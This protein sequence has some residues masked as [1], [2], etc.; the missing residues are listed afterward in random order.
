MKESIA[1]ERHQRIRLAIVGHEEVAA[2][3]LEAG[4]DRLSVR[5]TEPAVWLEAHHLSAGIELAFWNGSVRHQ[6]EPVPV[7]DYD[8]DAGRLDLAPPRELRVVQRRSTFREPVELPVKLSPAH[9]EPDTVDLEGITRDLSGSGMCLEATS[10]LPIAVDDELQVEL[11]I[12]GRRVRARGRVCWA[13][14]VERGTRLGLAFTRIAEK[15]Q[16]SVYGYLFDLQ[17]SRLRAS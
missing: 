2:D 11:E 13:E 8:L 14:P 6:S 15:E 9:G 7:I 10:D 1:F 16:D 4:P 17:R 12:G 3:V 5:L